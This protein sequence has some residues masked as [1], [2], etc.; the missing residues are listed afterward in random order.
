[1]QNN[2]HTFTSAGNTYAIQFVSE[3]EAGRM[4]ESMQDLLAQHHQLVAAAMIP[5]DP[6]T[7]PVV[8][9]KP[10]KPPRRLNKKDI[11][12]PCNFKHVSGITM[13]R[14]STCEQELRGTIQRKMRSLSLSNLSHHKATEDTS[15]PEEKS[16]GRRLSKKAKSFR[17]KKDSVTMTAVKR[18]EPHRMSLPSH[19]QH[20]ATA[21]SASLSH[22]PPSHQNTLTKT[23]SHSSGQSAVQG[24]WSGAYSHTVGILRLPVY[25]WA[26]APHMPYVHMYHVLFCERVSR[27]RLLVWSRAIHCV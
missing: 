17:R 15:E 18:A 9:K 7:Q 25:S 26:A 20:M 24:M 19:T 12:A 11:S 10:A 8:F 4:L 21:S 2:F 13:K 6:P 16:L 27:F 23:L 5:I 14:T 22:T 3:V 1:M